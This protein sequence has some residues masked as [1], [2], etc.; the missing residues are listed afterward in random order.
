M[1]Y[2]DQDIP[3]RL[4]DLTE[5]L[6]NCAIDEPLAR[7]IYSNIVRGSKPGH[8]PLEHLEIHGERAGYVY[9]IGTI[10]NLKHV[11][12]ELSRSRLC[13]LNFD[14]F[15]NPRAEPLGEVEREDL[16]R[17]FDK[18]GG[19][20]PSA[21]VMAAFMQLWPCEKKDWGSKWH[22]FPLGSRADW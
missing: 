12:V 20:A 6:K 11:A 17:S 10:S 22:S 8:Y 14:D 18:R 2:L 16:K 3:I 19:I 4:S 15:G 9:G 7:D 13:T 21:K 1:F 5:I